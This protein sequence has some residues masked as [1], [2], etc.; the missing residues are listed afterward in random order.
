MTLHSARAW[1]RV[2][3][4]FQTNRTG[5]KGADPGPERYNYIHK[6]GF[7]NIVRKLWESVVYAGM[8]PG[9]APQSVRIARWFGPLSG[10]VERFLS[11]GKPN[12]PLYLTNRSFG[13]KL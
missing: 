12:D 4:L 1:S 8:K 2:L 7:M 9:A 3:V 11:A 13:Q 6:E 10:P 5:A